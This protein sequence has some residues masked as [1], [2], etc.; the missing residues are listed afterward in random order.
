MYRLILLPLILVVY[1]A[2][3]GKNMADRLKDDEFGYG[4]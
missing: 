4:G 2:V 1:L 3:Y